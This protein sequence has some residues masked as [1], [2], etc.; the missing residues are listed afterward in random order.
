M[1][2]KAA[3]VHGPTPAASPAPVGNVSA[4]GPE[5]LRLAFEFRDRTGG[6]PVTQHADR[7]PGPGPCRQPVLIVLQRQALGIGIPRERHLPGIVH[8]DLVAQ[9]P[10]QQAEGLA[11]LAQAAL[12]HG[13]AAHQM[14]V[15]GSDG[16]LAEA[17]APP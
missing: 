5:Q 4:N 14:V 3:P 13:V 8:Q 15:Q 11:R 16:P 9:G 2:R 10:S 6:A 12:V 1:E 7:R 17:R